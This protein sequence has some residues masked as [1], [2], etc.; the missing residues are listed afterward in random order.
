MHCVQLRRLA[1]SSHP[2]PDD[3]RPECSAAATSSEMSAVS[4]RG[5]RLRPRS[6]VCH[7]VFALLVVFLNA[8]CSGGGGTDLAAVDAAAAAPNDTSPNPVDPPAPAPQPDPEPTP[9]PTP[10]PQ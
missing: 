1:H 5:S 6:S 9:A 2:A 7:A 4:N 3:P 8:S 10:A